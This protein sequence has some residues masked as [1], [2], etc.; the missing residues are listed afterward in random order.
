MIGFLS[1]FWLKQNNFFRDMETFQVVTNWKLPVKRVP[2]VMTIWGNQPNYIANIFFAKNVWPLGLT[3][4]RHVLCAELRYFVIFLK[5]EYG[6]RF[7]ESI[8]SIFFP[9][10]SF[11]NFLSR[12]SF[13]NFQFFFVPIFNFSWFSFFPQFS[14][15]FPTFMFL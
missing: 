14:F 8:F 4:R 9:K 7:Y 10:F 5:R 2:F 1:L 3:A 12:F 15:Y 11:F 13:P 6:L